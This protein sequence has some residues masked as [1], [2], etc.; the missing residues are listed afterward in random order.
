MSEA[1]D[2]WDALY[3]NNM[4]ACNVRNYNVATDFYTAL[5]QS[6]DMSAIFR[7]A[8][9]MLEVGCGTGEF[10]R[11]TKLLYP[12]IDYLGLDIAEPA[13]RYAK[14]HYKMFGLRFR[15]ANLFSVN[16]EFDISFISNTIEHFKNPYPL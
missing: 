5:Q 8:N 15:E 7:S 9:K 10:G 3:G 4:D 11:I 6:E 13:I 12:H 1:K 2:Y 14:D 16:E